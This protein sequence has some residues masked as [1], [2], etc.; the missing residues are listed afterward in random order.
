LAESLAWAVK[1]VVVAGG[2][3]VPSVVVVVV[4]VVVAAVA[5]VAVDGTVFSM[6]HLRRLLRLRSILEGLEGLLE[7]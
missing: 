7:G 2:A 5:G 4:V 3:V 1:A 6:L